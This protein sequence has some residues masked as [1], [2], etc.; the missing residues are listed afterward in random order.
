MEIN[1]DFRNVKMEFTFFI[2]NRWGDL[3]FFAS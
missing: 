2:F 3:K 1:V